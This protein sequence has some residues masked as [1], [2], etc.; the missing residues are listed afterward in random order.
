MDIAL[1]LA[2]LTSP[3]LFKALLQQIS[4][5]VTIYQFGH[6]LNYPGNLTLVG[7]FL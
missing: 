7:N 1:K 5:I 3:L 2:I 4:C 6:Y